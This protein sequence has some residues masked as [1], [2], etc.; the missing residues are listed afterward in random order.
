MRFPGHSLAPFLLLCVPVLAGA[1][2]F[3]IA[4]GDYV[5]LRQAAQQAANNDESDTILL[6]PGGHYAPAGRLSLETVQGS[7]NVY[8][9]GATIDGANADPGRL[10]EVSDTGSLVV[11]DLTVMNVAYTATG[12]LF[13]GGVVHNQGNSE[14]RNLTI[15]GTAIDSGDN[16]V[17]GAV[18]SNTGSLDLKNVTLSGNTAS[19]NVFGIAVNNSG[20]LS[21]GNVTIANNEASDGSSGSLVAI[22]TSG[23]DS[24]V[25]GNAIL[26]GNSGDNCS[27]PVNSSGGNI[28]DDDSCELDNDTD[29]PGTDP[30]LG[31]LTDNGGG[32]PTHAPNPG[33]PAIDAA[34]DNN[35]VPM[36]ARGMPRPKSGVQGAGQACDAGALEVSSAPHGFQPSVTGS[37]FDPAQNGH[38][39][40]LELL[41]SGD[42]LV[43]IW[44]VFNTAGQRDWVQ[45]V[46]PISDGIARLTALQAQ[47]G[48]FPPGFD[49]DNVSFVYWG[50][51]TIVM[52][53]C[54]TGTA[55]W[56]PDSFG[57]S[58]G[59]M[60]LSRIANVAGLPCE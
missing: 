24:L 46:G 7:L 35:C 37:W 2:V 38:G 29:H 41:P 20:S 25:T 59:G 48:E 54:N 42:R 8:A 11:S 4:D 16:N 39:F 40:T 58:A 49:Q 13:S 12:S 14:L 26:A 15:T 33:S 17:F 10:F 44:F 19:G 27:G 21:M 47:G 57:Y 51:L 6:A 50:T 45:A 43:A 32:I 36:D 23:G 5:A 3:E 53:D 1:E 22:D 34:T 30:D 9:R 28:A 56:M 31:P 55:A 18:I 52:H 60:P